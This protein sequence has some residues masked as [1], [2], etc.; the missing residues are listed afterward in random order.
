M[1]NSNLQEK[2]LLHLSIHLLPV[3]IATKIMEEDFSQTLL[4][5]FEFRSE[6][7]NEVTIDVISFRQI[8]RVLFV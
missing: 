8:V 3:S 1:R 5:Q 2:N 6:N 7:F 4:T